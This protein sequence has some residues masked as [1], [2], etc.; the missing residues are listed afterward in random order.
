MCDLA[1]EPS[2]ATDAKNLEHVPFVRCGPSLHPHEF[3]EGKSWR[4]KLT[5]TR[6]QHPKAIETIKATG[7]CTRFMNR[8]F[9]VSTTARP[10]TS[11]QRPKSLTSSSSLAPGG[12]LWTRDWSACL[13]AQELSGRSSLPGR[14]AHAG[15]SISA[16]SVQH[17][18]ERLADDFEVKGERPVFDVVHVEFKHFLI[19]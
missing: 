1:G 19:I 13:H 3:G 11:A 18:E 9:D 14:S 7:L 2:P 10:S 15:C 16:S 4:L 8:N 17:D 6:G 5:T 12:A